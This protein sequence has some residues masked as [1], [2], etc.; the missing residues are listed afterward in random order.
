MTVE[1]VDFNTKPGILYSVL[2]N[3]QSEHSYYPVIIPVNTKTKT[4]TTHQLCKLHRNI[5]IQVSIYK[6]NNHNYHSVCIHLWLA[7]L[8]AIF[9]SIFGRLAGCQLVKWRYRRQC[10]HQ[11]SVT[12]R[13]G[14]WWAGTGKNEWYLVGVLHMWQLHCSVKWVWRIVYVNSKWFH[15]SSL[16]WTIEFNYVKLASWALKKQATTSKTNKPTLIS[17]ITPLPREAIPRRSDGCWWR[18]GAVMFTR[19]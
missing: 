2:I 3:T 9:A 16:V 8:S 7:I 4:I 10:H 18:A 13:K 5:T 19:L 6:I 11:D 17:H 12:L 15:F 14:V 1:W